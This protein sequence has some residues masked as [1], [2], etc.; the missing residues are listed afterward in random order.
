MVETKLK[1]NFM[2][3]KFYNRL[4]GSV[5]LAGRQDARLGSSDMGKHSLTHFWKL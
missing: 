3:R 2:L 1:V 5:S 4:L